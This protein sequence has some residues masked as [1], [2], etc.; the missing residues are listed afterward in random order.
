MNSAILSAFVGI[1]LVACV[2]SQNESECNLKCR[3]DE[4]CY[5]KVIV[6]IAIERCMRYRRKGNELYIL[7]SINL[8]PSLSL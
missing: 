2:Q 8:L 7:Y 6:R 1:L 4:F 3:N 5:R